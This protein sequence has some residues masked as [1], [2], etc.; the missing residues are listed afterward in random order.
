MVKR[1]DTK[2]GKIVDTHFDSRLEGALLSYIL[3]K[4]TDYLKQVTDADINEV[5]SDCNIISDSVVQSLVSTAVIIANE[6][7]LIEI[8]TYI[9]CYAAMNPFPIGVNLEGE[10]DTKEDI[11]EYLRDRLN[12]YEEDSFEFLAIKIEN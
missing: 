1:E 12:I 6:C 4:G 9:R 3:E 5:K 7:E 2:I 10:Y 8:L 11:L